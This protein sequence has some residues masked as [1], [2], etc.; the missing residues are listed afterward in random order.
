[1][2]IADIARADRGAIWNRAEELQRRDP[3]LLDCSALY[4]ATLDYHDGLV[5]A[6]EPR[7]IEAARANPAGMF[8]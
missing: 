6:S 3:G 2:T 4:Q 7:I 1:M 5:H 8:K